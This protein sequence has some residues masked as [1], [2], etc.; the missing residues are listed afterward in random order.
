MK[1]HSL[2]GRRR[3]R[4]F[5]H[6]SDAERDAGEKDGVPMFFVRETLRA[7]EGRGLDAA[8]IL[9]AAEI[10]S[11]RIDVPRAYVSAEQY[12][13]LWKCLAAALQD[14][15]FQLDPRGM[16][17]GSYAL[18]CQ[19]TLHSPSLADALARALRFLAVLLTDFDARLVRNGA[20]AEI[21]FVEQGA[22]RTAF[23]YSSLL[24]LVLSLAC[25]LV[26]RRIPLLSADIRANEDDA[27]EHYRD[28]LSTDVRFGRAETRIRFDAGLLDLKPMR[29]EAQLTR[30]LQEGP[31][32]ARYR[33]RD[34]YMAR[35]SRQLER[36]SPEDWPDFKQ[37]ARSLHTTPST[38]RRRLDAERVSYQRIKDEVRR[39]RAINQLKANSKSNAE[40][41][42]QLG[43]EDPSTFYRAFKKWT[44]ATPNAF[45]AAGML[46]AP[47]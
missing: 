33:S 8:S 31:R 38:L 4:E 24:I 45:R 13:Q 12:G 15:F 23:A 42:E 1:P 29:D 25:W 17:P 30:F 7:V 39:D 11:S 6:G 20:C 34:S 28:L 36:L 5:L 47:A 27:A 3:S 46:A 22:P 41:A 35:I 26:D 21:V 10:C 43:Y 19:A 40:I 14:E 2:I 9:R 32:C 37:L 44:G 16:P 18:L